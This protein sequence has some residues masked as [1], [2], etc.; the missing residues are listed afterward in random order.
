M[1]K[2]LK[3]GLMHWVFMVNQNLKN[4]LTNDEVLKLFLKM[5]AA[6]VINVA[7]NSVQE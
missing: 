1:D 3:M 7:L 4:Q 2:D 6:Y 5:L